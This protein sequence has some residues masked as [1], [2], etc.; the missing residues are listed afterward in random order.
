VPALGGSSLF[1]AASQPLASTSRPRVDTVMPNTWEAYYKG[2]TVP[3]AT[4]VNIYN[5]AAKHTDEGHSYNSRQQS[6]AR[7]HLQQ[8]QHHNNRVSTSH[9]TQHAHT[10]RTHIYLPRVSL[11]KGPNK[12]L[13]L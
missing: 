9:N 6:Q 7:I 4:P 1:P 11:A 13:L 5:T 12:S 8:P 2:I 3:S 10:Y